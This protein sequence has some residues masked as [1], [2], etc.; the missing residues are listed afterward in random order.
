MTLIDAVVDVPTVLGAVARPVRR[1]RRPL[2]VVIF[3]PIIILTTTMVLLD[4]VAHVVVVVEEGTELALAEAEPLGTEARSTYGVGR[5]EF[6]PSTFAPRLAVGWGGQI[7][8]ESRRRIWHVE[9]QVH[10]I[11]TAVA[12]VVDL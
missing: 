9:V 7:E 10:R 3:V 4:V 2:V 6:A 11:E 1:A 5:R 12:V 8:F